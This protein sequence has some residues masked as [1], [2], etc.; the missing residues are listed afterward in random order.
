MRRHYIF[1]GYVQG[2]GFRWKAKHLAALHSVTGYV[3][4]LYDGTVE[5]EAE[6]REE[7]IDMLIQGLMNDR[8]I[9]ITDQ[10]F[11]SVPDEGSRN[12]EILS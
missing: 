2:V 9:E 3:R 8:Y 10:S 4:N 7:N 5:L 1:R 6:G 12:F 11:C